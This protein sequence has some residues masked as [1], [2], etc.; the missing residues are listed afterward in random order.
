ML[1]FI[2]IKV[3]EEKTK[4]LSQIKEGKGCMITTCNEE[5]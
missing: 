4:K 2:H 1:L 5:D 3:M